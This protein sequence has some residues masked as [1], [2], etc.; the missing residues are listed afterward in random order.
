MW[1]G[2]D[3]RPVKRRI[4]RPLCAIDRKTVEAGRW[5]CYTMARFQ[6]FA[7]GEN[8]VDHVHGEMD[9]REQEKVFRGFIWLTVRSCIAIAVILAFMA[10]FLT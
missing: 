7:S 5:L 8:M 9:I 6:R 2:S 10:A 1:R 3:W 4:A